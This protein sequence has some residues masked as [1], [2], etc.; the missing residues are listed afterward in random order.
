MKRLCTENRY[1]EDR[2]S[3]LPEPIL[4]HILSYLPTKDATKT[5]ALSKT[6]NSA[7]KSF[8]VLDFNQYSFQ[9]SAY[10]RKSRK[11]LKKVVQDFCDYVQE[12][13]NRRGGVTS[14][15]KFQVVVNFNGCTLTRH[16][17]LDRWLN[18]AI[19]NNVKDLVLAHH[20][21]ARTNDVWRYVLPESLFTATSL[22]NLDL[23]G[24][25]FRLSNGIGFSLRKLR[26][27]LVYID[28]ETLQSVL[29]H[30]C[31]LE[32][33]CIESCEGFQV[34]RV[35]GLKLE[36]VDLYL[37]RDQVQIVAVA[38]PNLKSLSYGGG[39]ASVQGSLV[40]SKYYEKIK[41]LTLHN[42]DI[43]D[44]FL[45]VIPEFP[46]LEK[47]ELKMCCFLEKSETE[48]SCILSAGISSSYDF[49]YF[50][51]KRYMV[52]QFLVHK[53]LFSINHALLHGIVR[54]QQLRHRMKA[55]CFLTTIS[56]YSSWSKSHSSTILSYPT[57]FSNS[58]L[59]LFIVPEFFKSSESIQSTVDA[60]MFIEAAS[61]SCQHNGLDRGN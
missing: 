22:E 17:Y 56:R 30:C 23:F 21:N 35:A 50:N 12:S 31:L 61:M 14:I 49:L 57:T 33:L 6:W 38:A 54:D 13:I 15:Q 40:A 5:C 60:E 34:V 48:P 4:H 58:F 18:Y 51:L 19:N 10:S 44:A 8:P 11:N 24:C 43:T 41:E 47:L 59:A 42:L 39:L 7:W 1:E 52:L 36:S 16:R 29:S 55:E 32:E 26:L 27:S 20:T 9:E 46:Q 3:S 25:Q 2:I 37:D 28:E 53:L 45:R